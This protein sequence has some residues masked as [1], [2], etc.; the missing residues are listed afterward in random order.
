MEYEVH[1]QEVFNILRNGVWE[2]R[3]FKSVYRIKNINGEFLIDS[4]NQEEI[5][6]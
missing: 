2:I 6:R 5:H 4:L 3:E 1:V